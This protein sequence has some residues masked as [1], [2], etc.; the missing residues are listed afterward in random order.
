MVL[1]L[2]LAAPALA[3]EWDVS[4]WKNQMAGAAVPSL[5]NVAVREVASTPFN[6]G[7]RPGNFDS[8]V[9]A[10]SWLP[11]FCS[12]HHTSECSSLTSAQFSANN[13]SLHGLW[14]DQ[15]GDN[16]HNYGY[17]GV[18]PSV[19]QMGENHAWCQMPSFG[20]SAGALN[21]L[22]TYM[23][24]TA[25]CLQNHEWYRHGS[26][27]AMTPDNYFTAAAALTAKFAATAAGRF[28]SAHVGQ[29][30]QANDLLSAFESQFG[31]GSRKYVSL[32]CAKV[33]GN[34]ALAEVHLVLAT[35][36]QGTDFAK[37]LRP[38]PGGNCPA[39]FTIP[40]A[41]SR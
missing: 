25:S 22:S 41:G 14:P 28:V 13:L 23:P 35:P 10:L 34:S 32:Q 3:G 18:D 21:D 27:S 5:A 20:M 24:G 15:S 30:V 9:L 2:G 11:G 38:S 12:L 16:Q 37:M 4:G 39:S 6:A 19:R 17:C 29:T 40:A 7:P 26:C 1:V 8:Y 31:A 33:G 36:L